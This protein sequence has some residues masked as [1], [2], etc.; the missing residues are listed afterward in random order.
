MGSA[1][2]PDSMDDC[3]PA[4]VSVLGAKIFRESCGVTALPET[5]DVPMTFSGALGELVSAG[6]GIGL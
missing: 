3:E 4:A 1:I 6:R 5:A 2:S